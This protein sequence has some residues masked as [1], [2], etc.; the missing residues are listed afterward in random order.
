MRGLFE[1]LIKVAAALN[2]CMRATNK[3][4]QHI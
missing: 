3:L 1:L 4:H 2:T